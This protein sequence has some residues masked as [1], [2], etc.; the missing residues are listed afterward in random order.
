MRLKEKRTGRLQVVSMLAICFL[1]FTA[2]QKSAVAPQLQPPPAAS[3]QRMEISTSKLV[4]LAGNAANTAISLNWT[5]VAGGSEELV[6]YVIECGTQDGQFADAIEI[7]STT[8]PGASFTVREFNTQVSKLVTPGVC[9]RVELRIRTDKAGKKGASYSDPIALDVTPYGS[10]TEYDNAAIMRIPGNYQEWKLQYAAKIVA[11][12][13]GEYEGY[14]N[15]TN[16][17]SQFLMVKG[18]TDWDPKVTYNYIGSNKFGFGGSVFSIFGG[19]GVYRLKANTQTNTWS[20]TKINNWGLNGSA[21]S[22]DANADRTMAFDESTLSWKVTADLLKG[23]FRFRA[24]SAN[25]V[26]FGHNATDAPGK[27]TYDGTRIP[28]SKAGNYT[29][30]LELQSAGNYAY[31]IHRNN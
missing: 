1:F 14:I 28:I 29:I 24:N 21:V 8:E 17:Y 27:P 30:T 19:A 26:V 3:A 23:D 11:A 9:N 13:P 15:F 18:T 10:Y 12:N 20:Y 7:G 4:L 2:C 25:E 22:N 16:P 31:S 6:K 5:P